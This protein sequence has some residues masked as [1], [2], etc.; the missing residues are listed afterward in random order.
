MPDIERL[1][2]IL[3][4]HGYEDF[5]WFDP[6]QVVVAQWVRMKCEFG[7]PSYGKIASCPP[8]TPSVEECKHF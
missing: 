8:N 1:E 4:Q 6:K 7:C 5:K 2:A 3:H